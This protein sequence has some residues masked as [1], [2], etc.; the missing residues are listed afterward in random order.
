MTHETKQNS[1]LACIKEVSKQIEKIS[2]PQQLKEVFSDD[3]ET[4][5][6]AI[7]TLTLAKIA[8]QRAHNSSECGSNEKVSVNWGA[9]RLN[10]VVAPFVDIGVEEMTKEIPLPPFRLKAG[11]K[12]IK[13]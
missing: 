3:K 4:F 13:I 6:E 10:G 12:D 5:G 1:E 7:T 8:I 11:N 9:V 2:L